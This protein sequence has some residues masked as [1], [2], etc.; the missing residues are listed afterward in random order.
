M[1][2]EMKPK[3]GRER[4]ASSLAGLLRLQR[5]NRAF[6][7]WLESQGAGSGGGRPSGEVPL[8]VR[9]GLRACGVSLPGCARERGIAQDRLTQ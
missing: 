6:S 4:G 7:R 2:K 8:A 1:V 9:L 3:T 5:A